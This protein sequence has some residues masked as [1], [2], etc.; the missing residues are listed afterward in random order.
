MRV[1]IVD[2]SVQIIKRLEEILSDTKKISTVCRSVSY[3]EAGELFKKIKQEVVIMDMGLHGNDAF[4]LINV[5]KKTNPST[6]IIV[7]SIHMDARVEEQCNFLGVDFFLDKYN[8]F[9]KIPAII[10]LVANEIKQFKP[11]GKLPCK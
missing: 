9:G 1:L 2:S 8:E 5:I 11:K 10:N 3:E 6:V 7:L 4:D